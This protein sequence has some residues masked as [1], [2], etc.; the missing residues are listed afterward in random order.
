MAIGLGLAGV[1]HAEW[2]TQF[3]EKNPG[4]GC[5]KLDTDARTT[6][7]GAHQG[8]AGGIVAIGTGSVGEAVLEDGSRR[9]VGGWGFPC[10]DEAGGAW[11]GLRAM[12]HLQQVLDGRRPSSGFAMELMRVCCGESSAVASVN[13][14]HQAIFSW[15]AKADQ[16]SYAQLA[17]IVVEWGPRDSSACQM[18]VQAGIEIASMVV[19]LDPAETIPIALCGGLAEALYGYIPEPVRQRI[20]A[21]VADS[22][23]G[24]LVLIHQFSQCSQSTREAYD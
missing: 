22:A 12:N 24:A 3:A 10:G 8:R 9:E 17:P 19:A 7:L 2:A 4:F 23:S 18:L 20:V 15:L 16:A 5:F 1:H 13:A 14:S 11:L 6:L 21:P